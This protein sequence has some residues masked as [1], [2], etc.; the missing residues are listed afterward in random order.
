MRSSW[1][2]STIVAVCVSV[3]LA[4][5]PKKPAAE[6]N[7]LPLVVFDDF[8]QGNA[9][10][11]EQSAPEAWT[12]EVKGDNHVY[13]QF[14]HV[15]TKTPV[16]SPFNRALIKDLYVSDCVLDVKL[17]STV[18]DYAHRSLCL[19]FGY[20]DPGHM[21]YVH[22]G[23][24]ADDHAN[25]IFIVNGEPRKKISV[26]STKG[27][28]WDDEWHHARVVRN[29]ATGQIDVYFDDMEKPV[30]RAVDKTFTWGQVGIGS[31]DDTG[32]F[33]DVTVYGKKVDKPSQQ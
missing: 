2:L 32:V 27:T 11:W 8:E 30:M 17:R 20:Q 25:Q 7:G 18:K 1:W 15:V 13:S 24:V 5:E 3:L 14:K 33:D 4:E 29:V 28:N 22:F 12:L 6:F 31:F 9:D 21:Y 23:K 10:R 26:E 19:F 16:R